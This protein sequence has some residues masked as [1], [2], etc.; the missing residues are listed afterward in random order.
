[1]LIMNKSQMLVTLKILTIGTHD[2]LRNGRRRG[3][4]DGE[5]SRSTSFS[6]FLTRSSILSRLLFQFELLR[7]ITS[8]VQTPLID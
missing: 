6:G 5:Q 8:C 4:E 2:H 1:M 3:I 7:S